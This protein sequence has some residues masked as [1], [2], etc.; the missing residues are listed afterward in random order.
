LYLFRLKNFKNNK[1]PLSLQQIT[2]QKAAAAFWIT[3]TNKYL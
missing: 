1:K 3:Q 2:F